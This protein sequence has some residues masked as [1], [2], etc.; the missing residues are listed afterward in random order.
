MANR[1]RDEVIYIRGD[2]ALKKRCGKDSRSGKRRM[3][4]G[5]LLCFLQ[6]ADRWDDVLCLRRIS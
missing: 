5:S 1:A 4:F 6:Q 2:E 3:S